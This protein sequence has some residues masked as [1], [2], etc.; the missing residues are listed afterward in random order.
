VIEGGLPDNETLFKGTPR[1]LA[2]G[3][4]REANGAELH[5]DDGVVTIPALGSRRKSD[6]IP[7]L[8]LGEHLFEG[9]RRNMVTFIDDH[10]TVAGDDVVDL[11]VTDNTL[12]HGD[13]DVLCWPA[14]PTTNLAY[15]LRI[16]PEEQGDLC[17]PLIEQWTSV[18]ENQR[19]PSPLGDQPDSY[20]CLPDAWRSNED[21]YIVL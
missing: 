5:L 4:D 21:S 7:G 18:Y 15:S 6:K 8:D 1:R 12:D 16:E 13:I 14:L 2:S 9:E 10:V 3:T 19:V 20:H 11:P 17:A